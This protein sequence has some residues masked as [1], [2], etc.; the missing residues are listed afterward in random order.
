MSQDTRKKTLENGSGGN[1]TSAADETPVRRTKR[2][3]KPQDRDE[4]SSSS[5]DGGV[6]ESAR[7][8]DVPSTVCSV[9]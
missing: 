8:C 6:G 9:M 2:K 5:G 4:K 7:D 3:R 1:G